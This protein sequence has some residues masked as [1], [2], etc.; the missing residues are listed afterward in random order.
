MTT[1]SHAPVRDKRLQKGKGAMDEKS[2]LLSTKA[3]KDLELV[4]LHFQA[5]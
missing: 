4:E 5:Q 2:P 1:E 3:E